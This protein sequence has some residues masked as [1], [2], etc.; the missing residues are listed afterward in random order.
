MRAVEIAEDICI[1]SLPEFETVGSLAKS[2]DLESAL[3]G[4]LVYYFDPDATGIL[5]VAVAGAKRALG[6]TVVP[7][8]CVITLSHSSPEQ[9]EKSLD[10][11]LNEAYDEVIKPSIMTAALY[12][13]LDGNSRLVKHP[14]HGLIQ[15]V[16]LPVSGNGTV[17]LSVVAGML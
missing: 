1:A 7:P 14:E 12:P 15:L 10:R 3:Q 6:M 13:G 16:I 5:A 2:R 11:H 4:N 8:Q 9:L 17:A